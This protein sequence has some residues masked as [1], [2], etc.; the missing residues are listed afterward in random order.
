MLS[1]RQREMATMTQKTKTLEQRIVCHI[2]NEIWTMPEERPK[3]PSFF[4][5]PCFGKSSLFYLP[6]QTKP[7]CQ[8]YTSLKEVHD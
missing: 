3:N 1:E 4:S 2:Q 8:T 7:R 5:L 6:Y